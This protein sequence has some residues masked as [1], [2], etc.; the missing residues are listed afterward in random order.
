VETAN[1]LICSRLSLGTWLTHFCWTSR[2][3]PNSRNVKAFLRTMAAA[4]R[5]VGSAWSLASSVARVV[6]NA[7]YGRVSLDA[8]CS[9]NIDMVGSRNRPLALDSAATRHFHEGSHLERVSPC[10][11]HRQTGNTRAAETWWGGDY[12]PGE[13]VFWRTLLTSMAVKQYKAEA[14]GIWWKREGKSS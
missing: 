13:S 5:T 11:G 9:G 2:N 12:K 8:A 6:R 4:Y 1:F 3:R 7:A 10:A 14:K